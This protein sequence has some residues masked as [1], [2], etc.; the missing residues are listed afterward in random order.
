M[1]VQACHARE[2]ISSSILLPLSGGWTGQK[3]VV[4]WQYSKMEQ[5]GSP[6]LMRP[7]GVAFLLPEKTPMVAAIFSFSG[8]PKD[9]L[10]GEGAS[11]WCIGIPAFPGSWAP[12]ITDTVH[13]SLRLGRRRD[14]KRVEVVCFSFC[15]L[16]SLWH[17]NKREVESDC[18]FKVSSVRCR[19]YSSR[20][21]WALWIR[22]LARIS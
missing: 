19:R 14:G 8:I 20:K 7:K 21:E 16:V 5:R 3:T 10:L 9:G 11:R 1:S 22:D 17:A 15:W 18:L 12:V 13:P 6:E 2:C 4:K